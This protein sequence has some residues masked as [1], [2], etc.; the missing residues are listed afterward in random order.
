[1]NTTR[2]LTMALMVGAFLALGCGDSPLTPEGEVSPQFMAGG[3][4]GGGGGGGGG[5]GSAATLTVDDGAGYLVLSDGQGAYTDGEGHVEV[6]I[7]DGDF[8]FSPNTH[9]KKGARFI[10]LTLGPGDSPDPFQGN[11]EI[12]GF[13]SDF[14]VHLGLVHTVT[15]GETTETHGRF[16]WASTLGQ[17]HL[18]FDVPNVNYEGDP[19]TITR[20]GDAD[21]STWTITSMGSGYLRIDNVPVGTFSLPFQF[22]VT[23][24]PGC[25]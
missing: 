3:G 25:S 2:H 23:G 24:Q 10:R 15:C 16:L 6:A 9:R 19:L 11:E 12:L 8:H 4:R 14:R 21:S 5:E 7:S 20:T 22:T 17:A 1:M 13:P 18:A